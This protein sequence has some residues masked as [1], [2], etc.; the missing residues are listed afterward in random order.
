MTPY[1]SRLKTDSE[2]QK[3]GISKQPVAAAMPNIVMTWQANWDSQTFKQF[4]QIQVFNQPW[5]SG[6]IVLW[7]TFSPTYHIPC[8][9]SSSWLI[10]HTLG[11]FDTNSF[12]PLSEAAVHGSWYLYLIRCTLGEFGLYFLCKTILHIIIYMYHVYVVSAHVYTDTHSML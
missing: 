4:S 11:C 10:P 6:E 3:H 5:H 8:T 12:K 2:L 7:A 9:F 1:F